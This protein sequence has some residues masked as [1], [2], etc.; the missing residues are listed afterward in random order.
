MHSPA[1]G[2]TALSA[3]TLSDGATSSWRALSPDHLHHQHALA[4]GAPGE[5]SEQAAAAAAAAAYDAA[6]AAAAQR[7][8]GPGAAAVSPLQGGMG[9]A[10]SAPASAGVSPMKP[11]GL[12]HDDSVVYSALSRPLPDY[13]LTHVFSQVGPG[14]AVQ[15]RAGGAPAAMHATRLLTP[16]A[17]T[18][19]SRLTRAPC[20]AAFLGFLPLLWCRPPSSPAHPTPLQK[21]CTAAPTRCCPPPPPFHV[22]SRVCARAG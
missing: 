16:H 3:P 13:A 7:G 2:A 12:A 19:P 9:Q 5:H 20:P 18:S 6:A 10:A 17:I 8:A 15:R 22:C 4:G 14:G 11:P 21:S 1:S